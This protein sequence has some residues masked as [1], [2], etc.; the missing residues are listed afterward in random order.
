VNKMGFR[1]RGYGRYYPGN[2]PFRDL[3]PWKRPGWQY[4]IGADG[5]A[6]AD[7]YSC[8]RFPWL[9]RRLWASPNL[10]DDMTVDS[11]NRSK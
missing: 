2:G 8:Q 5:A 1:G 6:I 10:T 4:R 3:P 9:P 11:T 7:P